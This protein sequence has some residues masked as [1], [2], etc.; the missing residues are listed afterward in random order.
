MCDARVRVLR[1]NSTDEAASALAARVADE[2][3]TRPAI[4][5]GLPAGR[6]MIPVYMALVGICRTREIDTSQV[7]TFQVDEY[8][9]LADEPG[10]FKEFLQR[11]LLLPLGINA[12]RAHFLNGRAEPEGECARYE[13]TIARAG[14]LDLQLL[15]IGRNGHIGFNEPGSAP[16]LRTHLVALHPET[17]RANMPSFGN[18]LTRV[19]QQALSMGLATLL[20]ARSIALIATGIDKADAVARA[21]DG[22]ITSDV[23]ASFLQR[24]PDV[25]VYLDRDAASRTLR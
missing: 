11:H 4:V 13:E 16:E 14:G 3:S 1:F 17:R 8:V 18:D 12:T 5:L 25:D 21:V 22:P 24:H 9:G 15:G 19:P 6:T 2:I 7:A 10:S 20:G 23:P